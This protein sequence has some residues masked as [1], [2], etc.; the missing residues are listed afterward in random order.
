MLCIC[1]AWGRS[2]SRKS[3]RYDLRISI[4]QLDDARVRNMASDRRIGA[5]EAKNRGVLLDAAEQLMLEE[6][7]AAVTSRRLAE[8]A[9]LKPQLV[10]YY[11]RTMEDLFLAM[12]RR[13]AEKDSRCRRGHWSHHSHCGHCGGST[14]TRPPP[15]TWNSPRWPTT[16]SHCAPKSLATPSVSA[17]G[18]KGVSNAL[19]RYDVDRRGATDRVVGAFH[20]RVQRAGN[21]T[22]LGMSAGHGETV[23][24]VERYLRRLE[25]EP[26]A[27]V[28]ATHAAP[29]PS[30]GADRAERSF[31]ALRLL[32]TLAVDRELTMEIRG[33]G[34]LGRWSPR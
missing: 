21:G 10:H 19:S 12:F 28:A 15:A 30:P 9:G 11:F 2:W 13:R 22:A 1:L 34:R 18:T 32:T 5:P 27:T 29:E 16:V 4:R 7:Y 3:R 17:T 20:Q 23:E 26:V 31:G 24:L 6:G 14:P 8:K 33:P 25:G